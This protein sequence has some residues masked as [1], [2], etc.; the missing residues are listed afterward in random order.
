MLL[1]NNVDS[2]KLNVVGLLTQKKFVCIVRNRFSLNM[3]SI[4]V[5]VR[6]DS[7]IKP[8]AV[9]ENDSNSSANRMFF[10]VIKGMQ[11]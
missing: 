2:V 8:T 11:C 7:N 4:H 10:S 3:L 6:R 1:K 5:Y 9:H